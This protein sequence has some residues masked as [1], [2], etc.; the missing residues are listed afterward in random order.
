MIINRVIYWL[1]SYDSIKRRSNADS[2]NGFSFLHAHGLGLRIH[3]HHH[4][5]ARDLRLNLRVLYQKFGQMLIILCE[6]PAQL[7]EHMEISQSITD[8]QPVKILTLL[9]QYHFKRLRSFGFL[10]GNWSQSPL[11]HI[12]FLVQFLPLLDK[13]ILRINI[14]LLKCF[15]FIKGLECIEQV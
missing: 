12:P 4:Q 5:L 13:H 1:L 3:P 15:E 14:F 11:R 2:L 9:G 10:S 7:F 8:A 6:V